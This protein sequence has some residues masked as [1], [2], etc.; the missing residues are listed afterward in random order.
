M[1]VALRA[2]SEVTNS[3]AGT[4]V[5]LT[6][7]A[8]T[9][10]GDVLIAF[11][12]EIGVGS[13]TAPAGWTL[14]GSEPAGSTLTVAAYR[15]VAASEGASWTWTLGAS[16]SNLGWVG[17]FTGV[18][19][20]APVAA[21]AGVD[22]VETVTGDDVVFRPH[23]MLVQ[24][25][26]T[27]G[28]ASGAQLV[29]YSNLKT[30]LQQDGYVA[31]ADYIDLQATLGTNK[32]AGTD[33]GMTAAT[34][35]AP[36]NLDRRGVGWGDRWLSA[37]TTGRVAWNISLEPAVVG[38]FD[39]ET[40]PAP[41][42]EAAF[43]GDPADPDGWDFADVSADVLINDGIVITSGRT[44]EGTAANPTSIALTFLSEAGE[45]H[46][47]NPTGP[48]FEEIKRGL[49]LRV[50]M[51]YGYASSSLRGLAFARAFQPDWD[52]TTRWAV[53]RANAI[54]R[55]TQLRRGSP[56]ASPMFRS[57]SGTTAGDVVPHDYWPMQD[58]SGST[59]F[60]S[61]LPGRQPMYPSG[62][63]SFAADSTHPGSDPLPTFA[64]GS[65][66]MGRVTAY[67]TTDQW[68]VMWTQKVAAEP[69]SETVITEIR[70]AGTGALWRVSVE[71]GSPA[72]VWFRLYDTAGVLL[73][74]IGFPLSGGFGSQPTEAE[75]FGHWATYYIAVTDVGGGNFDVFSSLTVTDIFDSGA[76]SP[77][78]GTFGAVTSVKPLAGLGGV[79]H[80][81]YVV[82]IGSAFSIG[83]SAGTDVANNAAA[84]LGW[85]RELHP[86]RY[87]RVSREVGVPAAMGHLS[88]VPYTAD[89]MGVQG[90]KTLSGI[91][92][93]IEAVNAGG[94]I[95]DARGPR[96]EVILD[97]RS[98]RYN[99]VVAMTIDMGQAQLHPPYAPRLDDQRLRTTSTVTRTGGSSGTATNDIGEGDYPDPVGIN[100]AD[101]DQPQTWAAWR[102]G[103]GTETGMR[104]PQIAINLRANP[105]L[106]P[107]FCDLR[108]G[109]RIR[110]SNP[111]TQQAPD[112]VD[113][114]VE[115]ITETITGDTWKA[116]LHCSP[117]RP[118]VVAVSDDAVLGKLD[119]GGCVMHLAATDVATSFMVHMT[120]Q[121]AATTDPAQ[122]PVPIRVSGQDNSVTAIATVTPAFVA[123][124]AV[125]HAVNA[126]VTPTMPA[127]V[128]AG[129]LLLVWAA[130][131]NS[132]TVDV[133]AGYTALL[134]TGNATLLGK[135]HTGTEVA[136][137]ITFSGGVAGADTSAQMS[138]FRGVALDVHASTAQLNG[139]AQNIAYPQLDISRRGCL[140]LYLGWKAD[141]WTSVAAIA[142]A[143]EIG[144]PDTTTGDDQGIVWDYVIQTSPAR[145]ASGSF[146]VTG[147]AAADSRGA[148]IALATDVQ[149][150]T[151]TRGTNGVTKAIAVEKPVHT[152]PGARLAL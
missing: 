26:A 2:D 104:Y 12:A 140:V 29:V 143:T 77:I 18:D 85:Y 147:G 35:T 90:T 48:R 122:M 23:G 131:R 126:S 151:V 42:I 102:V 99:Q 72:N 46:P 123:A 137:T 136:P 33:I 51:P 80:G 145:V 135:I 118:Y 100:L 116:V 84:A 87:L 52:V 68:V 128:Q 103:I 79:S 62:D 86:D 93:D 150:L 127:S 81:H 39:S 3:S 146:V 13:I 27:V 7:P 65:S 1:T 78:V 141:D 92:N 108:I 114:I 152:N 110:V 109:D 70:A 97:P 30:G 138:A 94:F 98:G 4:S 144:E 8:G 130:V 125:A 9:A 50:T 5:V 56:L 64:A 60:A 32:G 36:W 134:Q 22:G 73:N 106:V 105:E 43:G 101:D 15:K 71:P 14:I 111:P 129:D 149:T 142:G 113:L 16:V 67:A 53:V 10:D 19:T 20:T 49:P 112:D 54:G 24:C 66:A 21:S 28:V 58:A 38:A 82:F 69:A 59:R 34:Y 57:F 11:V 88:P 47:D 89:E 37:T 91:Y 76:G 107:A 17:A 31:A 117:Y 25:G 41:T 75:F 40:L 74:G 121:P 44:A 119:S 96:G 115:G 124:G 139:S 95:H 45:W 61:A 133:P 148:V 132:G 83:G 6:K 120:V 63:V 55:L